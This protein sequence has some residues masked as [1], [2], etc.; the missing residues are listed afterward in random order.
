MNATN[1]DRAE[2]AKSAL[3]V[4]AGETGLD[5]DVEADGYYTAVKDL[6]GDLMHFCNQNEIDFDAA[7]AGAETH[8]TAE[9]AEEIEDLKAVVNGK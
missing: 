6:L 3:D 8:F 5:A 7:L 4:F 9:L 2:W 1:T